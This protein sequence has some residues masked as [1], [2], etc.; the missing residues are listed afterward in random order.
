MN[1]SKIC[2]ICKENKGLEEYGKHKECRGG[3][4]T[5]CK[6]CYNLKTRKLREK[7]NNTYTKKY[8]KTKNGFIMRMYRNMKSRITGVQKAKYYLYENKPLIIKEDFYAWAK[9]NKQFD[10]LFEAYKKSNYQMK[11]APSIDRIDSLKGYSIDN[12]QFLTHSENSR[13]AAM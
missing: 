13:K 4:M 1:N 2:S 8:E 11:L 9:N 10:I 5:Y 6:S 7:N 12:M 3:L